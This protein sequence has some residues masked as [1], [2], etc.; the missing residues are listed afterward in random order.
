MA[1]EMVS[2]DQWWH[3]NLLAEAQIM[4]AEI[5]VMVGEYRA[6]LDSV[7]CALASVPKEQL[8]EDMRARARACLGSLAAIRAE[9]AEAID[10]SEEYLQFSIEANGPDDPRTDAAV[11][12]L[13][14]AYYQYGDYRKGEKHYRACYYR[15]RKRLGEHAPTPNSTGIQLAAVLCDLGEYEE[16]DRLLCSAEALPPDITTN[17]GLMFPLA[18]FVRGVWYLDRFF[19]GDAIICLEEGVKSIKSLHGQR[20]IHTACFLGTLGTALL[21]AGDNDQ[22][23]HV[24]QQTLEI[25]EASADVAVID[26]ADSLLAIGELY[27]ATNRHTEAEAAAQRA[28]EMIAGK[29]L[30]TNLVLARLHTVLA[31]AIVARGAH[32][33]AKNHLRHAEEIYHK[34]HSENGPRTAHFCTTAADVCS[35]AGD[36]ADAD[37]YRRR[38]IEI[39]SQLE[40]A[41]PDKSTVG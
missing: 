16:A 32:A 30:P 7:E 18:R 31:S 6:S 38:A 41:W 28:N 14:T 15:Q 17:T 35:V 1:L 2:K 29:L 22:A 25:Y 26:V 24:L 5:H 10:F 9:F 8:G 21:R 36:V 13:A 23:E 3:S 20:H 4:L 27:V 11:Y 37:R 34:V 33:D 12:S 39:R 19:Y 40:D